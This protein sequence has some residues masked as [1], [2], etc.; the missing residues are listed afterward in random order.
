MILKMIGAL[1]QYIY[2]TDSKGIFV[3]LFIGSEATADLSGNAI[4]I[5]QTTSYPWKG[6]TKIEIDPAVSQSFTVNIR[7]PGWAQGKENPEDLY[8]A[9]ATANATIKVN[10][11][12]VTINPVNGYASITR[13]WAKGD[14][15]HLSL[16]MAPRIITAN[17]AVE[18]V[19][20]KVAIASGPIV[21][22]FETVDNPKLK[23]MKIA[24][25]S[26]MQLVYHPDL[27]KGINVVTG[28]AV[29]ENEKQVNFKAVP[30]YSLGNREAGSAY[31]VWVLAQ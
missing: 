8:T 4:S 10:G 29:D 26:A 25:D 1:P 18:S 14:V 27:L 13:K 5:R 6:N 16:P 19:K 3:N 11:K 28:K 31:Q 17:P 12:L 2:A 23:Q 15:I 30:F 9:T 7:I 21:Y 24:T 22:S 20:G